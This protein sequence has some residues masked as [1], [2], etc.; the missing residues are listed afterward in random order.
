[1]L[2]GFLAGLDQVLWVPGD[3]KMGGGGMHL[4]SLY[5]HPHALGYMSEL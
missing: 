1:M 4:L 3:K 2:P 5:I